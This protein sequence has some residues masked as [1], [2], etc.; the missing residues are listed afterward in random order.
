MSNLLD[1]TSLLAR[2]VC[3]GVNRYSSARGKAAYMNCLD[4]YQDNEDSFGQFQVQLRIS[5]D[6]FM[7]FAEHKPSVLN[8]VVV[9]MEGRLQVFAGQQSFACDK[10]INVEPFKPSVP[11]AQPQAQQETKKPE[12]ARV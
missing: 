2:K 10:V 8:P 12:L 9:T 1:N 11:K 6:E 5:Y 3:I 4:S 7:L